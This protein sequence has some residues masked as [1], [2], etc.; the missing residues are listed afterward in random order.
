MSLRTALADDQI[1][2]HYQPQVEVLTGRVVAVE[3]LARWEH[4]DKGLLPAG[5]FIPEAE[6]TGLTGPLTERVLDLAIAQAAQW[7]RE[8]WPVRVAVNLCAADLADPAL[9]SKVFAALERHDVAPSALEL[10]V[11]ESSALRDLAQAAATLEELNSLG[12]DVAVDDY[13]A[14]Y[15]TLAHV[16]GL[17]IRRLKLDRTLVTAL[18]G[19]HTDQMI[20]RSTLQLAR[21]LGVGVV[22]EGVEDADTLLL[23]RDL[24]C[25]TA[26][27]YGLCHPVPADRAREAAPAVEERLA[28]VLAAA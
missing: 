21:E 14:G 2:L 11:T 28:G 6:A 25:D 24:G 1:V 20:V 22:A 23:L 17:P 12:V 16:K 19:E 13:G 10:E 27:G 9:T 4:P 3:A 7:R 15:S 5:D 18:A 8:G 26:Q